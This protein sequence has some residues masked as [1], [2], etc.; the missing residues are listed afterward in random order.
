MKGVEK[1]ILQVEKSSVKVVI[2]RR[3]EFI[4]IL[5]LRGERC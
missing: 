5:E 4:N 1:V 2:E 3:R